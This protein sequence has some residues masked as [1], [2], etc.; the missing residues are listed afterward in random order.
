MELTTVMNNCEISTLIPHLKKDCVKRDS[1]GTKER[2]R[3]KERERK[4]E[5][6]TCTCRR[7]PLDWSFFTS[8]TSCHIFLSL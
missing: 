3:E 7:P 5:R 2:E 8:A 4:R 1:I 6:V